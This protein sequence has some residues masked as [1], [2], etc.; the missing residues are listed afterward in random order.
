[1]KVLR[2][3]L[4]ITVFL[5]GGV[6]VWQSFGTQ[7]NDQSKL[8]S[9]GDA[10]GGPFTMTSHEGKTVKN[11][12]FHG[13]YQ[14]I[15]FG[16]SYCPDVCPI[17][18]QKITTALTLMD[19]KGLKTD[20]FQPLFISVDPERDTVSELKRFMDGFYP[21]FIGL[22]SDLETIQSVAK[23]YKIF[24]GKTGGTGNNDYLMNHSNYIILMGKDGKFLKL[25]GSIDS[26]EDIAN[27][28]SKLVG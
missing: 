10:L 22:T 16:Y 11:T 23:N 14:I 12:D 28:L 26:A 3:I 4:W 5:A 15:Y 27:S 24:F 8:R 2:S 21:S 6:L 17:E 7:P 13:R 20:M 19:Q 1:M 18:L 25:F 9:T